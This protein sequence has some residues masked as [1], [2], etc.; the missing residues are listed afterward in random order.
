MK[1]CTLVAWVGISILASATHSI[2]AGVPAQLNGK[3]IHASYTA[4]RP[5]K[6]QGGGS[7]SGS[8]DVSYVIYVSSSGRVFSR[9]A[10][11]HARLSLSR[12][13]AP[14][15]TRWHAVGGRLVATVARVSGALMQTISFDPNFQSCNISVV[16]G[17]ESGQAYR[18]RG[19]NGAVYEADG[20][21]S[22]S[23][24]SCSIA[25]G[26]GL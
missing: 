5:Y 21:L 1:A 11:S 4:T 8:K 20:P 25:D 6:L 13:T 12:E 22:I 3:T 19:M 16:A 10:E 17:H 15:V 9:F 24:Q 2:A 7:G 23:Q 14:E 26:N 18:W